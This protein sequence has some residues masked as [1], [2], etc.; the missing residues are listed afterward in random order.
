MVHFVLFLIFLSLARRLCALWCLSR[1]GERFVV[2]DP[3]S[4]HPGHLRVPS[5]WLTFAKWIWILFLASAVSAIRLVKAKFTLL[6]WF[7]ISL[8]VTTKRFWMSSLSLVEAARSLWEW[9]I[10]S[11]VNLAQDSGTET[12]KRGNRTRQWW[13]WCIGLHGL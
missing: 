10:L 7:H 6:K 13:Q 12:L 3:R 2:P 8:A 5:A 9:R 11:S 4:I 1:N